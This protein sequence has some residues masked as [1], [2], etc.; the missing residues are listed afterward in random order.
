MKEALDKIKL[1]FTIGEGE[2]AENV[3]LTAIFQA[4]VNF[5]LTILENEFGFTFAE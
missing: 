1:D 2:K 4:I 5:V 3:S